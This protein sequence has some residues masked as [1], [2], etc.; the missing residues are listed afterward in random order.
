MPHPPQDNPP[1]RK[2]ANEQHDYAKGWK[3]LFLFTRRAHLAVFIPAVLISAIAGLLQP[4]MAIL[5]GRFFDAFS[6]YASQKINGSTFMDRTL[7]NVHGLLVIGVCTLLL[8][9]SLLTLWLVFGELQS[10]SVRDRLFQSLLARETKW[11]DARTTGVD[12]LLSRLQM[13]CARIDD[14]LPGS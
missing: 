7:S 4:A 14:A 10:K 8:K 11:F 9:G 5:F 6:D 12:T 3:S 1:G 13:Y 2:T